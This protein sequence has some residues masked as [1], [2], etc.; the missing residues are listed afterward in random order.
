MGQIFPDRSDEPSG[1]GGWRYLSYDSHALDEATANTPSQE[2]A[3][4]RRP[5]TNRKAMR[6]RRSTPPQGRSHGRLLS[7]RP[8]AS[9]AFC[10][11]AAAITADVVVV[12]D[13]REGMYWNSKVVFSPSPPASVL[14]TLSL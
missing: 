12:G 5:A 6:F 1:R 10:S 3:S 11:G 7:P 4:P 2:E 9:V 13:P 14:D 8:S